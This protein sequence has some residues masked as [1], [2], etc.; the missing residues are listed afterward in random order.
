MSNWLSITW[1]SGRMRLLVSRVQSGSVI[2][3]HADQFTFQHDDKGKSAKEQ[4]AEFLRKYRYG[5][6]DTIVLLNRSEVEVRPM[7]FPPVPIDELSDLVR[8]QAVKEFNAYDQNSPLDYFVTNKFENISRSALF[9]TVFKSSE[10][11]ANPANNSASQNASAGGSPIH[12]LASTIR[13]ELFQKIKQFCDESGLNLKHI[14]LR[15]CESAYLLRFS[16]TFNPVRTILLLEL[17]AE[18]I[19]HIV[20]YQGE[21]VFIRSPKISTPTDVTS[22]DFVAILTAELRRTMIA[23]RNEIQ[24]V[25]VDDVVICGADSN[26]NELAKLL[27]A[28]I[29][30]PVKNFDTWNDPKIASSKNN[31]ARGNLIKT[32]GKLQDDLNAKN[33]AN[34]ERYAA[35][36]GSTLRTGKNIQTDI[37]FCNPKRP[38]EKIGYRILANAAV[39]F[40]FLLVTSLIGYAF[41]VQH[42]LALSNSEL[43]KEKY[44]LEQTAKKIAP[45][46][47]QLNAIESWQTDKINWF[48]Q[49]GWLSRNAPEPRDMM[50]TNLTLNASQGGS[51]TFTSLVRNSAI[52]APMEEKLRSDNHD[53][54]TGEK[55][56]TKGTPLYNYQVKLSVYL[57]KSDW[58]L[59]PVEDAPLV[60]TIKIDKPKTETTS[61][62]NNTPT[63]P[64][65][66]PTPNPTPPP[67]T[68]TQQNTTQPPQTNTIITQ[69]INITTQPP[70]EIIAED[71]KHPDDE[72][73]GEL[74]EEDEEEREEDF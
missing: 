15:P 27:S 71:D 18:E 20:I 66:T 13:H 73:N 38:K 35:L 17:D 19:S 50:I 68:P 39:V 23:V 6:L 4:L 60:E 62:T 11:N 58:N 52:V 49:L 14:F 53:V 45:L 5:K 22:P 47:T 10:Q 21:P 64:P 8:F 1:E 40:I 54:K 30:I 61:T 25:T 16:T 28:A 2:F 32:T 69:P 31:I 57:M 41:Y 12:L 26:F 63:T 36:I 7:V 56:E 70:T 9:P 33:I 37:D 51:M 65:A 3:E 67:P 43:S 42:S 59:A 74:D 24:G 48:E 55:S 34:P 46:R 72:R 44:K 29:S